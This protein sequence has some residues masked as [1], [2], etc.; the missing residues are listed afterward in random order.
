MLSI[1]YDHINWCEMPLPAKFQNDPE[2]QAW[3]RRA[4]AKFRTDTWKRSRLIARWLRR[5]GNRMLLDSLRCPGGAT[6]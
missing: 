5:Y 2:Y 3:L 1:S 4:N 6:L